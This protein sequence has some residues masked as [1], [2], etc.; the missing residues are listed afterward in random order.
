MLLV[1]SGLAVALPLM[2]LLGTQ[3][4]SADAAFEF[5]R[6]RFTAPFWRYGGKLLLGLI[7]AVPVSMFLY[8]AFYGFRHRRGT[9]DVYKRQAWDRRR[10]L[11]RSFAIKKPV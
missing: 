1:F 6:S 3:L 2:F 11:S 9:E 7:A 10:V 8:G 4:S 5:L